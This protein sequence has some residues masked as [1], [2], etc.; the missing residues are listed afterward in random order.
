MFMK[1]CSL[2][3]RKQYNPLGMRVFKTFVGGRVEFLYFNR[4]VSGHGNRGFRQLVDE[5]SDVST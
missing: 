2:P 4:R 5:A 1:S 3:V